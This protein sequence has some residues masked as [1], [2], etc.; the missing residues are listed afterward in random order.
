MSKQVYSFRT[1]MD[2]AIKVMVERV[3]AIETE[4]DRSTKVETT[5]RGENYDLKR[6]LEEMTLVLS[7]ERFLKEK[8]HA[9]ATELGKT[10]DHAEATA[11]SLQHHLEDRTRELAICEMRL[12]RSEEETKA[13]RAQVQMKDTEVSKLRLELDRLREQEAANSRRLLRRQLRFARLRDMARSVRKATYNTSTAES[14]SSSS[15]ETENPS[16]AE[17]EGH[18][19]AAE[20]EVGEPPIKKAASLP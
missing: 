2:A 16:M 20:E 4:L 7:Q 15:D 18:A 14:S 17:A 6:K 19:T 13:A 9:H 1:E 5:T 3:N 12:K 10:V 8:M 11:R